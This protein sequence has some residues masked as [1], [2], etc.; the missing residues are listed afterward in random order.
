MIRPGVVKRS[1]NVH[2]G[3]RVC[4]TSRY[5]QIFVPSVKTTLGTWSFGATETSIARIGNA[6]R[7]ISFSGIEFSPLE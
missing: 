1:S 5:S 6:N 4:S 7:P 2:S 3:S